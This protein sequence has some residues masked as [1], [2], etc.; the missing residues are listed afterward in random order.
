MG[1]RQIKNK[2]ELTSLFHSLIENNPNNLKT[3]FG[4]LSEEDQNQDKCLNNLLTLL[5]MNYIIRAG[6]IDEQVYGWS[7]EFI[8]KPHYYSEHIYV[9]PEFNP[10]LEIVFTIEQINFAK[11]WKFNAIKNP[12]T[13]CPTKEKIGT[14]FI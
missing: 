12:K 10:L 1:I 8:E 7:C 14:P 6:T 4:N 3:I 11:R 5:D 13:L 2:K 9:R